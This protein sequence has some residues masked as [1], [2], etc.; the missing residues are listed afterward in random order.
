[1]TVPSPDAPTGRP[2]R[3]AFEVPSFALREGVRELRW[4]RWPRIDDAIA[5]Y[6]LFSALREQGVIPKGVRFQVCLPFP[7]S[8]MSTLRVDFAADYPV[9]GPAFEDLVTR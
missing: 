4:E 9:A 6:R 2:P 5:S 7:A 3:N 1:M 8:A